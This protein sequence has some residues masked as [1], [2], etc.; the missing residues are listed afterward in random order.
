MT[1]GKDKYSNLG[2]GGDSS[3]RSL[4]GVTLAK[5]SIVN[6]NALLRD[7]LTLETIEET[8]RLLLL[9]AKRRSILYLEQEK[10]KQEEGEEKE[11]EEA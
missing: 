11:K 4:I 6:N 9:L 5:E 10:K 1:Q 2:L 3:R 7:I 8:L